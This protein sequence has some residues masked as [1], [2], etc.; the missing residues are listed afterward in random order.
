MTQ[1]LL[2][3]GAPLDGAFGDWMKHLAQALGIGHRASG[4]GH[5]A[6]GIG[7]RAEIRHPNKK[8]RKA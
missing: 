7:H 1:G 3:E 6:S 4:I 2:N 5:R 8:P